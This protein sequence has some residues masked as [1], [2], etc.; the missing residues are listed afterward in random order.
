MNSETVIGFGFCMIW[1]IKKIAGGVIRLCLRPR[2]IKPSSICIIPSDH[3]QT[4]RIISIVFWLYLLNLRRLDPCLHVSGYFWTCNFFFPDSKIS[5]S[6]RI[7]VQIEFAR[8]RPSIRIRHVSGFTLVS[9]N[10]L[11]IG[12]GWQQSMG[13][14]ARD[15][16]FTAKN[17]ARSCYV[18]G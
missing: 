6:T 11:G 2:R 1:K 16:P 18:T 15:M 12:G 5:T 8:P 13:R 3:T 4:H 10:P 14:K 9:R 7:R 17:W